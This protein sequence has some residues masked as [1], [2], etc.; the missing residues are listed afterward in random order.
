MS[1]VLTLLSEFGINMA[2]DSAVTVMVNSKRRPLYG[3]KKLQP[4]H[5]LGAGISCWGEGEIGNIP[6]DMWLEDFINSN[7][8]IVKIDDFAMSLQDKLR[9]KVGKIKQGSLGFHLAGFVET[10]QG[11]LP[12][13]YHI[14][15]GVSQHKHI[16][17]YIDPALFNA[18]QDILPDKYPPG[19]FRITRNGDYGLYAKL[20][21]VIEKFLNTE[22]RPLGVQIPHP[23]N[24]DSLAE[25]L[26]F[27]IKTVSEIYKL[28]NLVPWI[29]GAGNYVSYFETG[30]SKLRNQ[31]GG[32]YGSENISCR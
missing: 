12:T 18:N 6:T 1:L 25:Y 30:N 2:A 16:N 22:V 27:Q 24:I 11:K 31:V 9:E 17:P 19:S 4:I 3:V 8:H 28:S 32:V 13:F 10:P 21:E 5:Y 26:R 29:G 14:H 15:N 23:L 7:Q 20:F